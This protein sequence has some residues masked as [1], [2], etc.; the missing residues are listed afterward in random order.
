ME[1]TFTRRD[2]N[3]KGRKKSPTMLPMR[4]MG[5]STTMFVPALAMTAVPTSA[6]PS[7]AACQGSPVR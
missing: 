7:R 5:R 2:V 4:P 3:A 1:T 6:D